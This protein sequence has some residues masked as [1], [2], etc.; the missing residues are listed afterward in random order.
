[1]PSVFLIFPYLR[2]C[3]QDEIQFR[4]DSTRSI[5]KSLIQQLPINLSRV[6]RFVWANLLTVST[7]HCTCRFAGGV[8]GWP[9]G[10]GSWE[11]LV[12]TPLVD[13][14]AA[15]TSCLSRKLQASVHRP[16]PLACTPTS[17]PPSPSNG[18]PL[19]PRLPLALLVLYITPSARFVLLCI[20]FIS[21]G[22]CT[23]LI[24]FVNQSRDTRLSER[25]QDNG[26]T[27]AN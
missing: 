7:P 27:G 26:R 23:S 24:T 15:V 13:A 25:K 1:M 21:Y 8:C 14:I 9:T 11:S 22:A 12:N 6:V 5:S 10:E 2:L 3:C 18:D 16:L 17:L 4:F 19:P 20:K